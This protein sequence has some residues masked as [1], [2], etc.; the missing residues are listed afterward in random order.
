MLLSVAAA[1]S[2]VL[3]SV[4]LCRVEVTADEII[5]CGSEECGVPTAAVDESLDTFSEPSTA[6][7][8]VS[9][10]PPPADDGLRPARS[11]QTIYAGMAACVRSGDTA[12][13]AAM[14][15]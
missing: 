15:A 3:G 8:D 14:F 10:E 5:A 7:P 4:E 2:V 12:R 6:E 9:E 11:A 1:L 13:A